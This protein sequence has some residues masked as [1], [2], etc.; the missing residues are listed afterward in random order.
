MTVADALRKWGVTVVEVDGWETRGWLKGYGGTWDPAGVV[1]HHT[2]NGGF[3]GVDAPSLNVC[4]DGRPDLAGPL[5]QIVLGYS[6]TA[7]LIA[8]LGANHAGKGGWR[9]LWGNA[10][11]WGIEAENNG[12]GE[13]W[14]D[15]QVDAFHRCCAALAE[16]S[17]F[18]A[19]DVC[20]HKEW[21]PQKIDPAGIDMNEFRGRVA[22]LLAGTA[23]LPIPPQEDEMNK[24][25][26]MRHEVS[27]S[28]Y[29]CAGNE[30]RPMVI[31]RAPT[32]PELEEL[33][34]RTPGAIDGGND[35]AWL[36]M[37]P[38]VERYE[39]RPTDPAAIAQAVVAA[40]PVGEVGDIDEAALAVA[41]R[42]EFARRPLS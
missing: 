27:G 4:I 17:G 35:G 15:V 5:C 19:D 3:R 28:V 34:R 22:D 24:H 23:Q 32:L 41:V 36:D 18:G 21:T 14:P 33:R 39:L 16:F 37:L 10:S 30:E 31:L 42:D 38:W 1:C 12:R 20:G 26:F 29:W 7:Y 2:A 40:L 11:V 25:W 9:E 8:G 13:P 6:G